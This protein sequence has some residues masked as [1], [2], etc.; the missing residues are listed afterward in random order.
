M[1]WMSHQHH[2]VRGSTL[3]AEYTSVS[4]GA[5]LGTSKLFEV[6]LFLIQDHLGLGVDLIDCFPVD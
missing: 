6:R 1:V 2:S 4:Q 5:L 3:G